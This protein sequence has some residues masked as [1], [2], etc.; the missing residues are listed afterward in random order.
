MRERI[1]LVRTMNGSV[2]RVTPVRAVRDYRHC[3]QRTA[4]PTVVDTVSVDPFRMPLLWKCVR[5][6]ASF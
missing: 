4:R 1:A 3:V 2:G 6:L 5:V